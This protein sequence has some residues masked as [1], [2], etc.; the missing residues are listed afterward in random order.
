MG[1]LQPEEEQ[2]QEATSQ[3]LSDDCNNVRTSE[4]D[5]SAAVGSV[6]LIWR[7]QRTN[8]ADV[9]SR[10]GDA[11]DVMLPLFSR[12]LY[13]CQLPRCHLVSAGTLPCQTVVHS[14]LPLSSSSV[15]LALLHPPIHSFSW[16]YY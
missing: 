1:G 8:P 6:P 12:L 4:V 7:F 10:F 14:L 16:F 9:N 11:H 2:S 3:L 15:F 13:G 5:R